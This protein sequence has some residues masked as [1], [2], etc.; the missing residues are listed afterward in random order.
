MSAYLFHLYQ[1][2]DANGEAIVALI[3]V[4]VLIIA[5]K[6]VLDSIRQL[7][8]LSL[9]EAVGG[10]V[11]VLALLYTLSTAIIPQVSD[12]L[13]VS[14]PHYADG[15]A[16]T[17]PATSP[18][19]SSTASHSDSPSSHP[20]PASSPAA[21]DFTADEADESSLF[22]DLPSIP[23]LAPEESPLQGIDLGPR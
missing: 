21:H 3:F 10:I 22:D 20:W 15:S 23:P 12:S 17:H 13:G 8:P 11:V 4:V 16:V 2:L 14:Q 18:S 6:R 5:A 19:S 9:L 7:T 1:S